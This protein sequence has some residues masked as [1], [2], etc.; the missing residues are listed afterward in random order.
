MLGWP[1][2]LAPWRRDHYF[3]VNF[4][5]LGFLLDIS[6]CEIFAHRGQIRMYYLDREGVAEVF[7]T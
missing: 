5:N 2:N 4:G 3:R 6:E 7:P 1:S